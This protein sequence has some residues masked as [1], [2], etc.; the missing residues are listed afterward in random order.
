MGQFL[1]E[2]QAHVF[3]GTY[4]AYFCRYFSWLLFEESGKELSVSII[5]LSTLISM[6]T[7]PAWVWVIGP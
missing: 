3:V 5:M 1:S 6:V 7:I 4:P 2:Y